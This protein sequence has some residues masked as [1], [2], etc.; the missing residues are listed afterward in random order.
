MA[1]LNFLK[2]KKNEELDIPPPPPIFDYQSKTEFPELRYS[3]PEGNEEFP[4]IPSPDAGKVDFEEIHEP[5]LF[6]PQIE[7]PPPIF[8]PAKPKRDALIEEIPERIKEDEAP[9]VLDR[10]EMPIGE[11][12]LIK[13]IE[14]PKISKEAII[15]EKKKLEK[16]Y[17]IN[18]PIFVRAD[19][20]K[21][22]LSSISIIKS[23]INESESIVTRLNEIKNTKDKEFE[24]W[25]N[26]LEEMQGKLIYID[27]N[28]F[29]R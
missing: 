18:K 13:E 25:K 28:L 6:K 4:P 9:E 11:G 20:Y 24:K 8:K 2:K 7:I 15:E 23:K 10:E 26:D 27:A 1:F 29:E 14:T 22:I 21:S 17:D 19:S 3:L 16:K 12:M 5:L